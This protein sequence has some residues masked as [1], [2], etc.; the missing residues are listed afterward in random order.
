M[1]N[2]ELA[3]ALEPSSIRLRFAAASKGPGEFQ[4]YLTSLNLGEPWG[5]KYLPKDSVLAVLS[6]QDEDSRLRDVEES[7]DL[8]KSLLKEKVEEKIF[9]HLRDAIRRALKHLS[10]E[11]AVGAYVTGNGGVGLLS[12][13][14]VKDAQA[15]QQEMVQLFKAVGRDLG[16]M[17]TRLIQSE[18]TKTGKKDLAGLGFT[19]K[20]R[21]GGVQVAGQRAEVAEVVIR[22]PRPK[23][24]EARKLLAEIRKGLSKVVGP[25][26]EIAFLATGEVLLSALGIEARKRLGEAAALAQGGAGTG[27]EKTLTASAAGKKPAVLIYLPVAAFTEGVLRVVDRLTTI[28]AEVRDMVH[29]VLPGAGKEAPVVG[30]LYRD[31]DSLVWDM[32]LSPDLVG[33]AAKAAVH[34]ILSKSGGAAVPPPSPRQ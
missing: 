7:F 32:S 14:R 2:L 34:M 27:M 22:W 13:G 15:A 5:A 26:L 18:V 6:R 1:K 31:Q 25:R 3:L 16:E 17:I 30:L 21:P 9:T 8:L 11:A 24:K 10:G 28:P 23:D 4:T 33:M 12:V 29:K 19:I 20:V